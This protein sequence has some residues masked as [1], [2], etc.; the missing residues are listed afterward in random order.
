M[1]GPNLF[2]GVIP[3][4]ERSLNLRARRHELIVSNIAN[5]D[6]PHYKS[7]DMI[8]EDELEKSRT[9]TSK[10][11]LAKT[12]SRHLSGHTP[13]GGDQ[14]TLKVRESDELSLRGDGNT[15]DI[16]RE[17]VNLSENTLQYKASAQ[18]MSNMFNALKQAING[19]K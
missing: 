2:S 18:I 7:F 14:V 15:V 17:M 8:I 3:L 1:S 5:A 19:G 4:V 11:P 6:T 13:S 12:S 10:V 9:D 16:D